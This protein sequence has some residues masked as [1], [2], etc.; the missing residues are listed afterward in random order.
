MFIGGKRKPHLTDFV[1]QYCDKRDEC[2]SKTCPQQSANGKGI[3]RADVAYIEVH[4]CPKYRPLDG[5][6]V[7]TEVREMG[8]WKDGA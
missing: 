4:H 3:I 8:V 1:I 6:Q 5:G 2:G 7:G